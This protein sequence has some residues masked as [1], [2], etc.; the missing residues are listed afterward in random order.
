MKPN[1]KR[2]V[3]PDRLD[4]R[5]RPYLPSVREAPRAELNALQ[6]FP[7]Q[8]LDQGDTSACTGFAL[9]Q[10]VNCLLWRAKRREEQPVSPYMLYSMA[11]RYDEFPGY[12]ATRGPACAA[13]SRVGTTTAPAD[14]TSGKT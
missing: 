3:V 2:T 7:L 6:G 12:T 9:S 1:F 14:T 5:D 13:R 4:L 11:R 8:A 10:V